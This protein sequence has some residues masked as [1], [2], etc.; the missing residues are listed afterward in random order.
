M[1]FGAQSVSVTEVLF[2]KSAAPFAVIVGKGQGSVGSG[3][4]VGPGVGMGMV[5]SLKV[6]AKK[7]GWRRYCELCK[8][9]TLFGSPGSPTVLTEIARKAQEL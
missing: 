3:T 2:V 8:L 9:V 4:G 1:A 6:P 7:P 5:G